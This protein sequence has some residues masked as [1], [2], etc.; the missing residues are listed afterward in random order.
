M[1][2]YV[3]MEY[4]NDGGWARFV[5]HDK[6]VAER[7]AEMDDSLSVEEFEPLTEVPAYRSELSIGETHYGSHEHERWE[8]SDVD[9]PEASVKSTA[10]TLSR[11]KPAYSVQARGTNH[12][13]VRALFAEELGKVK[14]KL[15]ALPAAVKAFRTVEIPITPRVAKLLKKPQEE[16][17]FARV[18]LDWDSGRAALVALCEGREVRVLID[19][20]TVRKLTEELP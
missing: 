5:T 3:L 10:P 11:G 7:M 9:F 1:T 13:K 2:V 16:L 20:K 17:S 12:A 19:E 14:A 8:W 6:A 18:G 15:S 4:E